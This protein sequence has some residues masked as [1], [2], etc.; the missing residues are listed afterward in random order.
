[1][2]LLNKIH[3][4]SGDKGYCFAKNPYFSKECKVDVRTVRRWVAVLVECR[5]IL[6]QGRKKRKIWLTETGLVQLSAHQKRTQEDKCP[7]VSANVRNRRQNVRNIYDLKN[8]LNYPN[9][10]PQKSFDPIRDREKK[11]VWQT[12]H[13]VSF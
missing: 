11:E 8:Y 1:M 9:I 13:G 5:L 3:A 7:E 2:D 12:A 4:L 10:Q 6:I